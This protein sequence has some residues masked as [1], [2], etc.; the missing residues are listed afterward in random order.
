M[1]AVSS[2][3]Y[4]EPLEINI[5]PSRQV[6][7][8][9]LAIHLTAAAVITQLPLP[10]PSRLIILVAIPVSLVWNGLMFWR[11][12]PKRLMWSRE[13]GWRI[14]D[15]K[16]VTHNMELLPQ[17]YVGNWML[18]AHFR[19]SQGK[20]RAVMLARDSCSADG[21][22]RLLVMLRYGTPKN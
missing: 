18:V 11:R 1:N 15:R 14:T 19:G 5:R 7:S 10:L 6:A 2:P 4:G 12:T 16:G 20:R 17:A 21:L 8:L 3:T 13:Q 9:V 22:R